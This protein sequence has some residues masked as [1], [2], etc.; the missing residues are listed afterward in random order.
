M[1]KKLQKIC[2][3][4]SYSKKTNLDNSVTNTMYMEYCIAISWRITGPNSA[5]QVNL[6]NMNK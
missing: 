2:T 1:G 3:V 4:Q 5:S 6:P